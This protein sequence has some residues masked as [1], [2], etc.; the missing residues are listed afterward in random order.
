MTRAEAARTTLAI[1]FV[2]AGAGQGLV[3]ASWA[4]ANRG[5]GRYDVP[6]ML[7]ATMVQYPSWVA[8]TVIG[9]LAGDVIGN[10]EDLGLDAIFPA[11]F[12]ALL[13]NELRDG[14]SVAAALIGAALA[15]TLTPFV[16]PGVPVLAACA[17]AA[18]GLVR[19]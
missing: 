13:V 1:F 11:F 18:L 4:I 9:V 16:P 2:A 17:G 6:Y 14:M 7:G 5:G 15:L 3:D 8:G 10:P 12:L 19:R